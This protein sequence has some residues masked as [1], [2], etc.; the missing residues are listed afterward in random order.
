[1]REK[2]EGNKHKLCA[3]LCVRRQKRQAS[4]FFFF[5]LPHRSDASGCAHAI[6]HVTQ[7]RASAHVGQVEPKRKIWRR[8]Q[9]A[10]AQSEALITEQEKM[11]DQ[12]KMERERERLA[13]RKCTVHFF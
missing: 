7:Q 12:K 9:P 3:V 11:R 13:L 4:V 6:V 1:M 8:P 2:R 5:G 10:V